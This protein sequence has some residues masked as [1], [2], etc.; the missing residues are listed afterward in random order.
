LDAELTK[1]QAK[2]A[3]AHADAE[4]QARI[5]LDERGD[6]YLAG[7]A[8]FGDAVTYGAIF[9]DEDFVR[10]M[11]RLTQELFRRAIATDS[12][13]EDEP[14]QISRDYEDHRKHMVVFVTSNA[15]SG[16][17][18]PSDFVSF[19]ESAR[20]LVRAV[21]PEVE[22]MGGDVYGSSAVIEVLSVWALAELWKRPHA[23]ETVGDILAELTIVSQYRPL[24]DALVACARG[25]GDNA[26]TEFATVYAKLITAKKYD[27][28][29]VSDLT[30]AKA[31]NLSLLR[32]RGQ[33]LQACTSMFNGG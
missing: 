25:G 26:L 27:T 21:E 30:M 17:E 10:R 4:R 12:Y 11:F 6:E 28:G 14:E 20:L 1:L 8:A 13:S 7:E 24:R 33:F 31:Y 5:S 2:Y 15:L 19:D 18:P 22:E 16:S 32:S 23:F 29:V 9:R 3:S